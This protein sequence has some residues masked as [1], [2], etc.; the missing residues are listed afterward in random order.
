MDAEQMEQ[1]FNTFMARFDEHYSR[2]P[3]NVDVGTPPPQ[4]AGTSGSR[5][6]F[7]PD[8]VG[9]FDPHLPADFGAGDMVQTGKD[10]M[11]RNIHM[12]MTRA[13]SVAQSKGPEGPGIVR[14]SLEQCLRGSA[15]MWHTNELSDLEKEALREVGDGLERWETTLVKRFK[16]L[17]SVSLTKAMRGRYTISDVKHQR[18]PTAYVQT[19]LGHAKA[20]GLDNVLNQLDLAW[21]NL[22]PDLQRDIDEPSDRTT[23]TEFLA[24]LNRKKVSWFRVY[25]R[26]STGTPAGGPQAISRRDPIPPDNRQGNYGRFSSAPARGGFMHLGGNALVPGGGQA[27]SFNP[28]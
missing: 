9:Y 19:L 7:R 5:P 28:Y 14:R 22:D 26:Q 12:F 1:M 24:Q 10:V 21:N 25:G 3:R 4:N 6:Q 8:E 15:L 11:Y 17:R 23:I 2:N 20:A 16:E 18:E 13:K 27:F